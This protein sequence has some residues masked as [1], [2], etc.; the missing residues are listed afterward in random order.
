MAK[1]NSGKWAI[2]TL[3]AAGVGYL[4]GILTA[5]KSGKETRKDIKQ[6]AN[7]AVTE[8]EKKLKELH[9]DLDKL[10]ASGR[11]RAGAAG[12][13][14]RTELDKALSKA[15]VA[16]DKARGILSAVHEGEADDKDLDKAVK[17]AKEALKHLKQYLGGASGK[18]K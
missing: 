1:K 9:S 17:E 8:S 13:K 15:Q 6:A 10:I 18:A 11:K 2:G 16:K 5:P 14:A 7:R 3:V 12:T 4:A